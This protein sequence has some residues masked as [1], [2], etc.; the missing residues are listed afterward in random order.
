MQFTREDFFTEEIE[1]VHAHSMLSFHCHNSYEIYYISYGERSVIF[2]QRV[3]T[4][5]AGDIILHRPNLLHKGTGTK[6][7]IKIDTEFSKNFLDHYFTETMQSELL[8]CFRHNFIHLRSAER[9]IFESLLKRL[10]E[11]YAKNE[12]FAVT[13]AEILTFLCRVGKTH[14]GEIYLS[15]IAP[16][17]VP[18]KVNGIIGYIEENF[19]RIRSVDE[20]AEYAYLDKS[21][22][23]RMF[24]KETGLTIMDFLY[25]YRIQQACNKLLSTTHPVSAVGELCGFENTSHFI[26]VFRSMLGCTPGQFRKNRK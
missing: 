9:G 18:E 1:S 11:E 23:C 26:R 15:V 5:H 24:K 25:N 6:P 20:I 12:L 3:Y 17:K 4:L 19:A 16:A 14:E 21:Y 22:L 7:H 8:D 10:G 13:L 2:D